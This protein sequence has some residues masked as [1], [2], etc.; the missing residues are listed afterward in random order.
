MPLSAGYAI[1]RVERPEKP[2]L[3]ETVS[4]LAEAKARVD[5]LMK[6][7]RYEYIIVGHAD[8]QRITGIS[9]TRR[10]ILAGLRPV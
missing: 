9:K 1:F 7:R 2:T 6:R 4:T 10:N 8:G 5:E 3:V